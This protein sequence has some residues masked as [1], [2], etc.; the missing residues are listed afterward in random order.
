M[1]TNDLDCVITDL[2]GQIREAADEITHLREKNTRLAA[3]S[4]KASLEA[5]Q[6]R[7]ALKPFSDAADK[8]DGQPDRQVAVMLKDCRAARAAIREGGKDAADLWHHVKTG[9]VYEIVGECIIEATNKPAVLYRSV[10]PAPGR[11]IWARPKDEF[12]DGRFEKV[13]LRE[14]GGKYESP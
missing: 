7:E 14:A 3:L 2:C 4:A 8:L 13:D 12:F 9:G 11:S 5:S 1:G 6:L 10:I